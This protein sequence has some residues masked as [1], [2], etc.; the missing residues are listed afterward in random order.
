[1][2]SFCH[3]FAMK[4]E[5]LK[6]GQLK[7]TV[8]APPIQLCALWQTNEWKRKSSRHIVRI[9]TET[10]EW[11]RAPCNERIHLAQTSHSSC[12]VRSLCAIAVCLVCAVC[13]CVYTWFF[14]FQ[15]IVIHSF[16]KYQKIVMQTIYTRS[17]K[18]AFRGKR[19]SLKRV[20]SAVTFG[21][22]SSVF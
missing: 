1:M 11:E 21:V 8:L 10:K 16:A 19:P 2:C 6:R 14:S 9:G 4:R 13:L 22:F 3:S 20:K 15:F 7:L 12:V 18:Y 5:W 17:G